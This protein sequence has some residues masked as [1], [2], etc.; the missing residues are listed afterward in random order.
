MSPGAVSVLR[1]L[2]PGHGDPQDAGSVFQSIEAPGVRTVGEVLHHLHSFWTDIASQATMSPVADMMMRIGGENLGDAS[3]P[4]QQAADE[5]VR[6]ERLHIQA[7]LLVRGLL[8]EG[9]HIDDT[10]PTEKEIRLGHCL[11]TVQIVSALCH[12]YQQLNM[13]ARAPGVCRHYHPTFLTVPWSSCNAYQR[14]ILLSLH[15]AMKGNMRLGPCGRA[16][17]APH[18]VQRTRLRRC[19]NGSPMCAKCGKPRDGGAHPSTSHVFEYAHEDEPDTQTMAASGAWTR[20]GTLRDHVMRV[21]SIEHNSARWVESTRA[22]KT[23]N[24]VVEYL[25]VTPHPELPRLESTVSPYRVSFRNCQYDIKLHQF[26]PHWCTCAVEVTCRCGHTGHD[27]RSSRYIDVWCPTAVMTATAD[28]SVRVCAECRLPEDTCRKHFAKSHEFR[29]DASCCSICGLGTEADHRDCTI[30]GGFGRYTGPPTPPC[31]HTAPRDWWLDAIPTPSF[32]SIFSFQGLTREVRAWVYV[33]LGRLLYDL[34]EFDDH[35]YVLCLV[36]VAGAGKSV[37]ADIVKMFHDSKDVAVLSS[38]SNVT[39]GLA[40]AVVTSSEE[41]RCR[42]MVLVYEMMKSFP[43]T[44]GDFQSMVS[45]DV[46]LVNAKHKPAREVRWTA[47][48]FVIGNHLPSYSDNQ[49]S[50]GR[51][52]VIVNLRRAVPEHLKDPALPARIRTRELAA[53]LVKCNVAYRTYM[54]SLGRS[55]DIWAVLPGYFLDGRRAYQSQTHALTHFLEDLPPDL[56]FGPED[57][58]FLPLDDIDN[59]QG[60]YA[61]FVEWCDAHNERRQRW[62]ESYYGLALARHGC[63]YERTATVQWGSTGQTRTMKVVRGVGLSHMD[64]AAPSQAAIND[65]AK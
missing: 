3:P 25:S 14:L 9:H 46:C 20:R 49:G 36:G 33:M 43:I 31:T 10:N 59:T 7:L 38:S 54:A 39:F 65:I 62:T 29:W 52:M 40:N 30:A 2:Y 32:D 23:I 64:S 47:P 19:E 50:I 53:L 11:D 48:M 12:A 45:G 58:T 35:Q 44:Q 6:A 56:E 1:Q 13:T 24:S 21:C 51:R 28:P 34:R 15:H 37:V 63:R 18:Q 55:L 41:W 60:F 26:H 16:L 27:D 17:F 4:A 5:L 57:T 8:L 22:S 61:R 42:R